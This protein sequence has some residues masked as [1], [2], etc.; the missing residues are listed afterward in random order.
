[1]DVLVSVDT[2]DDT[3]SSLVVINMYLGGTIWIASTEWINVDFASSNPRQFGMLVWWNLLDS[4]PL[5]DVDSAVSWEKPVDD[6][7]ASIGWL[8]LLQRVVLLLRVHHRI[9]REE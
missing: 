2:D 7:G 8:L 9:I 1:M 3:E 4:I 5:I 6:Y